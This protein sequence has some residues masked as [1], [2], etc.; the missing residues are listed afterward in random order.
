MKD[1]IL[2]S[3]CQNRASEDKT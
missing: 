2:R 1:D 3:D